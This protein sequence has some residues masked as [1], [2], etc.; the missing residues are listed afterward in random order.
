MIPDTPVWHWRNS[1]PTQASYMYWKT[2]RHP[3]GARHSSPLLCEY[4]LRKTQ[5]NLADSPQSA[6]NFRTLKHLFSSHRL[7]VKNNAWPFLL[8]SLGCSC[9]LLPLRPCQAAQPRHRAVAAAS[10][11]R[12]TAGTSLFSPHLQPEQPYCGGR[13]CPDIW[14]FSCTFSKEPGPSSLLGCIERFCC[15]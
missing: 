12:G 3:Q 8:F 6:S 9:A 13:G 2:R 4:G 14:L 11:A 5:S 1:A 15:G 10:L 7:F